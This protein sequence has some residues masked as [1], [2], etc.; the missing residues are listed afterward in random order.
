M[1]SF[2]AEESSIV[3]VELLVMENIFQ[4]FH[5]FLYKYM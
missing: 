2:K 5:S 1:N 3:V 4:Y